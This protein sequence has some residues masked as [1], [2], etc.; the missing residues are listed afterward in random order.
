MKTRFCQIKST[1]NWLAKAI[2]LTFLLAQLPLLLAKN[3]WFFELFSHYLHYYA[4]AALFLWLLSL[5]LR[6]FKTALALSLILALHLTQLSPYLEAPEK[7]PWTEPSQSLLSQNVYYLNPNTDQFLEMLDK[8]QPDFF[9]IHEAGPAWEKLLPEL[10]NRYL[11]V[12]FGGHHGPTGIIIGSQSPGTFKEIPLGEDLALQ[13]EPANSKTAILAVHP[14]PGMNKKMWKNY[15]SYYAD[16]APYLNSNPEK[17]WIVVGDF[18]ATPWSPVIKSLL[19]DTNLKDSRI[20]FGTFPFFTPTWNAH[21]PLFK[22]PIDH[23]LVSPGIQV[24]N[25]ARLES[26]DSDHWGIWLEFK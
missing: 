21:L 25:F 19:T 15:H 17:N 11:H 24:Q 2:F 4:L 9:V 5:C 20:G 6:R 13:F 12:Q 10:K 26:T 14:L 1:C 23:A 22:I 8:H 3:N 16:L 7:T 18:N